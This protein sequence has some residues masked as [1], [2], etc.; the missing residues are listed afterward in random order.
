MENE[1]YV[2]AWFLLVVVA[3]LIVTG[4]STAIY[5]GEAQNTQNLLNDLSDDFQEQLITLGINQSAALSQLATDFASLNIESTE[6]LARKELEIANLTAEALA[7]QVTIDEQIVTYNEL[8]NTYEVVLDEK[9]VVLIQLNET[10]IQLQETSQELNETLILLDAALNG[11]VLY[12]NY[13]LHDFPLVNITAFITN[14]STNAISV[15]ILF[16]NLSHVTDVKNNATDLGYRCGLLTFYNL[17][18]VTSYFNVFETTDNGLRYFNVT[19]Y[20]FDSI[21]D[22]ETVYG[23]HRQYFTAW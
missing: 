6:E 11:T 10:I 21:T 2:K 9:N 5:F 20:M 7:L 4:T 3:M 18:N 12:D 23:V 17:T 19:D 15:D 16:R 1:L 22:I 14:D 13:H 8:Y